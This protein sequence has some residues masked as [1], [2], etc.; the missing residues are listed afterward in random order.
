[1]I[2]KNGMS[3]NIRTKEEWDV[4]VEVGTREGIVWNS[5]TPLA[6]Y[7]PWH[8]DFSIQI[9]HD[10]SRRATHDSIDYSNSKCPNLVEAADLF[11]NYLISRRAKS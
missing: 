7:N 9:G 1:M 4:F 8:R 11:H 5:G 10:H 6:Q 3:I 2:I